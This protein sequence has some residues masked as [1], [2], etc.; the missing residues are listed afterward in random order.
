MDTHQFRSEDAPGVVHIA[1]WAIQK[2]YIEMTKKPKKRIQ[3]PST[4]AGI[5]GILL[6][7]ASL[8]VPV[9]QPWLAGLG[10]VAGAV[11]VALREGEK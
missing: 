7:A 8:P 5:S 11:A 9:A 3:E 10:A 4:W 2:G 6:S 1:G